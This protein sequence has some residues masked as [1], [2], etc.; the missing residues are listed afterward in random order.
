MGGQ[1]R[2]GAGQWGMAKRLK[3][4]RF[5]KDCAI[6]SN[7]SNH[8]CVCMCVCVCLDLT[9]Y[10]MLQLSVARSVNIFLDI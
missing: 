7:F 9:H 8:T 10:L 4:L 3:Q 5:V 6:S 2:S 1:R